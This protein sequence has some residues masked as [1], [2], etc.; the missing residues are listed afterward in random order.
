MEDVKIRFIDSN[1]RHFSSL[2]GSQHIASRSGALN[3]LDLLLQFNP[4]S[5]LDWGTGIETL[6]PLYEFMNIMTIIAVENK[7]SPMQEV[8]AIT[9]PCQFQP[10]DCEYKSNQSHH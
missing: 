6:M 5:V 3:L 4:K 7:E 10:N 9:S 1:F 2:P 8:N